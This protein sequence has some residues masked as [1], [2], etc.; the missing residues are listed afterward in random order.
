MIRLAGLVVPQTVKTDVFTDPS[1]EKFF[2][3]YRDTPHLVRRAKR[4]LVS[5]SKVPVFEE[6]IGLVL[7]IN[8][9]ISKV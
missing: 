7:S 5:S 9:V 1:Y 3:V 2:F 8:A 4:L 6:I